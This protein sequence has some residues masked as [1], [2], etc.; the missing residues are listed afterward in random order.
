MNVR[1]RTALAAVLFGAVC[2]LAATVPPLSHLASD[3][4]APMPSRFD[5]GV[6]LIGG[7]ALLAAGFLASGILLFKEPP[8][9]EGLLPGAGSLA[10]AAG[11]LLF[12]SIGVP[13][14]RDPVLRWSW[15]RDP[16]APVRI[17][18]L[19]CEGGRSGATLVAPLARPGSAEE[20]R[21]L[22]RGLGR[23]VP[24]RTRMVEVRDA[25]I[26]E[27][28]RG[29]LESRFLRRDRPVW[30]TAGGSRCVEAVGLSR[31]R[32]L[33]YAASPEGRGDREFERLRE[34][35]DTLVSAAR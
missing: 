27:A 13:F 5:R 8:G 14:V 34:I 6:L 30:G 33:Y 26:E 10:L 32:F 7:F 28:A 19:S 20:L 35:A 29:I 16:G 11:S 1:S 22:L 2:A 23:G 31:G 24:E 15:G 21:R 17:V 12:L 3:I 4:A 9:R 18:R 25:A